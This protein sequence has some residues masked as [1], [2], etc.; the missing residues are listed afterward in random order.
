MGRNK[1]VMIHGIIFDLD[2]CFIGSSEVQKG[3]YF[4]SYATVV[5]DN[6]CML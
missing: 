3:A 2:G 6:N 1:C 5:G 4:G